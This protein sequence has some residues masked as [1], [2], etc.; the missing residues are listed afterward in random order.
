MFY[1]EAVFA[2]RAGKAIQATPAGVA[3]PGQA[4]CVRVYACGKRDGNRERIGGRG[5]PCRECGCRA[6]GGVLYVILGPGELDTWD[7]VVSGWRR[8]K[9]E[10][11]V[12][13]V[14]AYDI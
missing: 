13:G 6:G 4:R 2:G 10:D 12:Q 3:Q 1:I 8:H 11:M 9:K 14:L 7:G 5:R